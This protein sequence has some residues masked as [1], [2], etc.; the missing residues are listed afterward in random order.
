MLQFFA[1]FATSGSLQLGFY[2]LSTFISAL[3]AYTD[4][5]WAG[6]IIDRCS[7]TGYFPFFFFLGY[8]LMAQKNSQL[9]EVLY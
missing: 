2:Y 6:D 7:L 1:S 4:A 3:Q 8:S 5:N 9:S